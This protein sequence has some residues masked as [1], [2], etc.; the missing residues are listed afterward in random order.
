MNGK[1]V[2]ISADIDSHLAY[3][4]FLDY[5]QN[6]NNYNGPKLPLTILLA[7]NGTLNTPYKL[8]FLDDPLAKSI[9]YLDIATLKSKLPPFFENL[10]TLLDKLC[11]FKFNRQTK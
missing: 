1:T 10:N 5:K 4:D 9:V 3:I 7:G 11:F 6:Q 8:N 2:R